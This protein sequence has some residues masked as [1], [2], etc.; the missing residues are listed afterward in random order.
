MDFRRVDM[1]SR[2][3]L[4]RRQWVIHLEGAAEIGI[5]DGTTKATRPEDMV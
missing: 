5:S 2:H 4:P 1:G 3:N